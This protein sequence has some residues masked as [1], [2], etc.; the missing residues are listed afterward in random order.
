MQ[1]ETVYIGGWFQR[2]TL[3]LSEIFDFLSRKKSSLDFSEH[4]LAKFH[5]ALKLKHVTRENWLLEYID[6]Q[7]TKE[8]KFRVYE[9]GLIVL[10]HEGRADSSQVFNRLEQYYDTALSPA[11]SFLFSKGAPVPKE[12][13]R[14]KSLLPFVVVT[15]SA[16]A[17]EA[18]DFFKSHNATYYAKLETP[19]ATVYKSDLFILIVSRAPA[20][21]IRQLVE[22]QI[23]FREFKAQLHRYLQ[24]HRTIW[25]EIATIKERGSIRGKD[26]K[27]LRARLDD[28]QKTIKLIESRINQMS[29]Y[30]RTRAKI[31]ASQKVE[32]IL[33]D[34]FVYKFETLEDTLS[35][36]RELWKMTDNYLSAAI[37]R[38]NEI[39]IESTK[40][41]ITSLR[42]ITTLGVVAGIVGYLSKDALPTV[43]LQGGLFFLAL[44]VVT[45]LFNEVV[46]A[47]YSRKQYALR[48]EEGLFG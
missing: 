48:K 11:I 8:M 10:E 31:A 1:I 7:V 23:F 15:K 6:A 3:H 5:D 16:S 20:E 12:L 35:Y 18:D 32:G 37:G 27:A 30:L 36:V 13:A 46:S 25:E 9:D 38:F 2:T 33:D 14:M 21:K 45:W 17:A 19:Q 42:L 43:T 4:D 44:L 22:G 26:V 47:Y 28:V 24:I 34:L 41:S 39:Q 40:N 29:A